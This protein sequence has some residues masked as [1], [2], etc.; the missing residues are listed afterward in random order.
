[1]TLLLVLRVVHILAAAVLV[2][3]VVFNYFL[4]RP[5]LRLIPPAHAVVIAQRVGTSFTVLG[6][7]ALGLLFL[8]G[9]LRVLLQGLLGA[10]LSVH[11][12]TTGHGRSLGLMVFF[13]F[14]TVVTSAVMTF[15][16][17]PTLMRKLSVRS[18]PQLGDVA[19]RQAAQLAAAGWM[20]RLQL[21]AVIASTA[22]LV[23]G[24]SVLLGGF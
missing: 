8:T 17:R 20:E 3:A 12:F 24:A 22:A 9:A 13:W 1:M 16:L 6:W 7:V 11:V 5:A 23:A 4:V 2:G 18:S 19:R 21:V 14:V 15:V 10:L